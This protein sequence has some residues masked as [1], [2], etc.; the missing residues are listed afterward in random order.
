[1]TGESASLDSLSWVV[2]V[3]TTPPR[4]VC[5][6]HPVFTLQTICSYTVQ[7]INLDPTPTVAAKF[8]AARS[9]TTV[10][11]LVVNK[12]PPA[13]VV[14]LTCAGG[15]C[16]FS[17]AH[18]VTGKECKGKPCQAKA[19]ERHTRPRTIDLAAL[20]AGARLASGARL[21]VSVTKTSTV[22]REWVFTMRGTKEPARRL[23]CLEPGSS[24]PGKG[25][26]V[27]TKAADPAGLDR[28]VEELGA[29]L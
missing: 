17:S 10:K 9:G 13:A 14:N 27:A 25:C 3:D 22:G 8:T 28:W 5:N 12:V 23:T 11:R 21:T 18:R 26:T 16:P 2:K 6:G 7:P 19:G 4:V 29:L 24:T 1:M 20:F 15:G